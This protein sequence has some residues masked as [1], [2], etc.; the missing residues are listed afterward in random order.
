MGYSLSLEASGDYGLAEV[1]RQWSQML[2][3][4]AD[5]PVAYWTGAMVPT[6]PDQ[7]PGTPFWRERFGTRALGGYFEDYLA[8]A[9]DCGADG[10]FFHSLCRLSGLPA[11][12]QTE[13]TAAVRHVF[14]S[15][16]R[17]S[18][19]RTLPLVEATSR[20][21]RQVGLLRANPGNPRYFTDGAARAAY[22]TGSHT[23][24]SLQDMG[25]TDP[26]AAFDF[27]A[28]LDFLVRHEH[29]FIRLWR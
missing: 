5:R 2:K 21:S 19:T 7:R 10:V 12:T 26:P 25:E 29:D 8:R 14:G 20:S 22:L 28:Y 3:D 13:V 6:D 27:V 23:W 4:V 16:G 1:T 17:R 15:M 18:E 11:E 24:N 9:W